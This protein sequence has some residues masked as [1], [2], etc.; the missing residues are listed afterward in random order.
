MRNFASF[1]SAGSLLA[2]IKLIYML[3]NGE[4]AP[5]GAEATSL[6]DQFSAS[7]GMVHPA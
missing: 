1:R 4:C 3:R 5:D 2:G 7:A 6:A